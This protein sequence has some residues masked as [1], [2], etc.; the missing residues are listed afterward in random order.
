MIVYC[1]HCNILS[2]SYYFKGV[3]KYAIGNGFTNNIYCSTIR[4]AIENEKAFIV[5]KISKVA[6]WDDFSYSENIKKIMD[7]VS[8]TVLNTNSFCRMCGEYA[9]I[10]KSHYGAHRTRRSSMESAYVFDDADIAIPFLELMDE[11]QLDFDFG[12]CDTHSLAVIKST[13]DKY[14]YTN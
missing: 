6:S 11:G 8:P 7:Y 13:L 14:F 1:K 3:D 10:Y 5:Q 9:V 2:L 12:K 4:L